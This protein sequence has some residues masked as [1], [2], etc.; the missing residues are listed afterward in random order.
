MSPD[1]EICATAK[2]SSTGKTVAGGNGP[3]ASLNQL[4]NP[5]GLLV[6]P[7]DDDAVIIVD[8]ENGRIMR[9][10]QGEINGQIIAGG[11]GIGNRSDQLALPRYIALDKKGTLFITEYTNKRV[12]RWEKGASSGDIIISNINANGI[13]LGPESDEKQSLFVGDWFSAYILKFN[14]NGTGRRQIVVG[15]NGSGSSLEQLSTPYQMY[16]D[17]LGSIY[18]SEYLNHRVT[19]WNAYNSSD[20]ETKAALVAGGNGNGSNLNQLD[21]TLAVT[22]DQSN[23]IYVADYGNHRIMRWLKGAHVGAVII[24][25]HGQG[26]LST[27][28]NH[29][30]DLAF[31]RQGNLFVSDFSNHRIQ[32][33]AVDKSSCSGVASILGIIARFKLVGLTIFIILFDSVI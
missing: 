27:Q 24:G 25:G 10:A 2:W 15:S 14:K 26:N 33:F 29:P 12:S 19:K 22:V 16:I 3:G 32:M 7:N 11:N 9:W 6:D 20:W 13:A 5:F 28:L 4:N 1:Y 21:G 31:D 17:P 18:I 8:H 23:N 30:Y